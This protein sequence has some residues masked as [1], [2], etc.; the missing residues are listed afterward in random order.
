MTTTEVFK[1][2]DEEDEGDFDLVGLNYFDDEKDDNKNN[3]NGNIIEEKPEDEEKDKDK[4]AKNIKSIN[5]R[6]ISGKKEGFSMRNF[7]MSN[8]KK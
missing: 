3:K 2:L 6:V 5:K 4:E 8:N 1:E 7:L